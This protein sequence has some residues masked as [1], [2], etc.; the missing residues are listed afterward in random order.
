MNIVLK[1]MLNK[2]QLLHLKDFL[3]QYGAAELENALQMYT[4][5]NQEYICK[6]KTSI[7]KIK[8]SDI[9][10]LKIHKHNIF[11]YTERDTFHKYGTLNN[12]LKILSTYNF[13]KCNQSCVVSLGK[14]KSIRNNDIILINNVKLHMSRNCTP[15]ILSAFSSQN[16]IIHNS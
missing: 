11:I 1:S 5:I 12:E 3:N 8:I 4:N 7:S 15:K 6:T 13:I 10:Y 2:E 14:I 16:S 9:Y